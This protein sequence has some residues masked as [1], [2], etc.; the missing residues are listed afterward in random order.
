MALEIV[1][2]H[3][4]H[5]LRSGFPVQDALAVGLYSPNSKTDGLCLAQGQ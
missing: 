5:L 2:V 4:L 1:M 3:S